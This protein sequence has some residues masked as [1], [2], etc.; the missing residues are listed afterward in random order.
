MKYVRRLLAAALF[1]AIL[2]VP[3]ARSL[4]SG[5]ATLTCTTNTT[6]GK[7]TLTVSHDSQFLVSITHAG[8]CAPTSKPNPAPSNPISLV[9]TTT[10]NGTNLKI[11]RKTSTGTVPL[12]DVTY[13]GPKPAACS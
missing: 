11:V 4:A 10:A 5:P 7:S 1:A 2:A 13:P 6:T 9:C 8:R 3:A 12:A